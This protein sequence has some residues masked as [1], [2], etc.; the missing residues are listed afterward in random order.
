MTQGMLADVG[1]ANTDRLI[2]AGR[3]LHMA[4]RLRQGMLIQ[5]RPAITDRLIQTGKY[6]VGRLLHMA[7]RLTQGG[8]ARLI[9]DRLIQGRQ[10][11]IIIQ[12]SRTG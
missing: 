12:G 9:Q 2:Q 7:A 1:Q 11:N 6:W 3:L 4:G 8:P 10:A 5:A